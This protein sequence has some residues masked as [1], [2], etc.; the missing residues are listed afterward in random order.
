M[1]SPACTTNDHQH[2][3][4]HAERA[5][6]HEGPD[7]QLRPSQRET[8]REHGGEAHRGIEIEGRLAVA[9]GRTPGLAGIA[10]RGHHDLIGAGERERAE[11][12]EV[13]HGRC[14]RSRS[15]VKMTAIDREKVRV[16][17]YHLVIEAASTGIYTLSL[18]DALPI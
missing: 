8:R 14:P 17:W 10:R 1:P 13:F 18:H 11:A 9:G 15:R 12:F 16:C 3:R 2:A 7:L 4:I 5:V 6:A